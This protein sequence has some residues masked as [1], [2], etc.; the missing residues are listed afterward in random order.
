[1]RNLCPW[2]RAGGVLRGHRRQ[3][4]RRRR[5][6]RPS[7]RPAALR[8]PLRLVRSRRLTSSAQRTATMTQAARLTRRHPCHHLRRLAPPRRSPCRQRRPRQR[9]QRPS[10]HQV[11]LRRLQWPARS[12]VLRS[13]HAAAVTTRAAIRS[14]PRRLERRRLRQWQPRR[15]RHQ[16]LALSLVRRRQHPLRMR[17][18]RAAP[19]R[20]CEVTSGRP[21]SCQH[22]PGQR[23]RL[24]ALRSPQRPAASSAAPSAALQP[25][26]TRQRRLRHRRQRLAA[27]SRPASRPHPRQQSPARLL[28]LE[29]RPLWGP[30]L[31]QRT[32]RARAAARTGAA[33]PRR[34]SPL[35]RSQRHA[36][37]PLH[38][39]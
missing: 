19:Q 4:R 8:N 35:R 11:A 39:A 14:P 12:E 2:P 29:L 9:A 7:A 24:L 15:A 33:T 25:A 31:P 30:Q 10:A 21:P 1:M 34:P 17:A 23:G 37:G 32:A 36:L 13:A 6:A 5:A 26:M 38:L 3:R 18:T 28:A 20:C 27:P 22:R 16:Q